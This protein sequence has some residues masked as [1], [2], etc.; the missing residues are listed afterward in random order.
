MHLGAP[1][2]L[3][4]HPSPPFTY[5]IVVACTYAFSSPSEPA[6][7]TVPAGVRTKN[8]VGEESIETGLA[9][10]NVTSHPSKSNCRPL[11]N[12]PCSYG[13]IKKKGYEGLKILVI[14]RLGSH[15]TKQALGSQ[16]PASQPDN[17]PAEERHNQHQPSHT[18]TSAAEYKSTFTYEYSYSTDQC[19]TKT[20]C[21]EPS[22]CSGH[23]AVGAG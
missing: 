2:G 18:S 16:A 1:V 6:V 9:A 22:Q 5:H 13:L 4:P 7:P 12:S 19:L 8:L 20:C 10:F 21:K 3:R 11:M 23:V 14:Q 15:K 17:Q